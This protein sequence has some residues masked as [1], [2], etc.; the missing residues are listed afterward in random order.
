MH[1]YA[2][3]LPSRPRPFEPG[4]SPDRRTANVGGDVPKRLDQG[5]L[6]AW[7]LADP[8]DRACAHPRIRR[9]EGGPKLGEPERRGAGIHGPEGRFRACPTPLVEGSE[10]GVLLLA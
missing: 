4:Q 3:E 6:D 10:L 8:R 7:F 5:F 1:G 9:G 2:D